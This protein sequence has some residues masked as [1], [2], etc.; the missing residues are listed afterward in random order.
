MTRKRW[1]WAT[2][3][4]CLHCGKEIGLIIHGDDIVE[5]VEAKKIVDSECE[6]CGEYIPSKELGGHCKICKKIICKNC[7]YKS[8]TDWLCE[9]C[10]HAESVKK[11]GFQYATLSE[12]RGMMVECGV[13]ISTKEV[14][15]LLGPIILEKKIKKSDLDKTFKELIIN[16]LKIAYKKRRKFLIF[17]DIFPLI[18]ES[19]ELNIFKSDFIKQKLEENLNKKV[20]YPELYAGLA[21]KILSYIISDENKDLFYGILLK[22]LNTIDLRVRNQAFKVIYGPEFNKDLYPKLDFGLLIDDLFLTEEKIS[23]N[24]EDFIEFASNISIIIYHH[25]SGSQI[26]KILDWLKSFKNRNSVLEKIAKINK[27]IREFW[28]KKLD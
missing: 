25:G 27:Q 22:S 14:V 23:K 15:Y 17:D 26:D 28:G 2:T 18:L 4:N 13:K 16:G 19:K 11:Y 1:L 6:N 9:E 20:E 7:G 5:I 10:E 12:V 8:D 21:L 24:E 3:A